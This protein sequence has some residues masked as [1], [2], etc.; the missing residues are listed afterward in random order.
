MS[1]LIYIAMGW[2]M[3]MGGHKFFDA[4]PHPVVVYICT[5][6]VIYT[7]GVIFYIWD[8][9]KYTHAVWHSF[10]IAGAACHYIGTEA[11]TRGLK[12]P[13]GNRA[14]RREISPLRSR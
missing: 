5:G 2:M 6:G 9:Y 3:V 13:A 1:T 8:K 14:W 7:I 11:F 4:L 10:V 12:L